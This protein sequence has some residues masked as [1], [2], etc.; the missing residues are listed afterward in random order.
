VGTGVKREKQ[1]RKKKISP[2]SEQRAT[3][4]T[5]KTFGTGFGEWGYK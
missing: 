5:K 3:E 1:G 4:V 2:Q